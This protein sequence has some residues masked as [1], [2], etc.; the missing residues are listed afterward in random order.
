MKPY[1]RS[2]LVRA[3]IILLILGSG[4]LVGFLLYAKLGFYHDPNPNPVLLGIP[5]GLTFW[6]AVILI[7]FGIARVRRQ[8][9][10]S[11]PHGG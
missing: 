8:R 7:M 9:M 5:A 2:R 3:G 10:A 6:P 1:F 11:Q 4:P